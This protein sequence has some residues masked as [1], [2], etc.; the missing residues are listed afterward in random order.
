[1]YDTNIHTCENSL[2]KR[3]TDDRERK[4]RKEIK[5]H[6]NGK[7]REIE[8]ETHESR[9]VPIWLVGS[10]PWEYSGAADDTERNSVDLVGRG[11]DLN[12]I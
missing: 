7:D 3:K 6:K 4:I 9:M 1:M 11:L 12:E 5:R 8:S 2:G 10:P